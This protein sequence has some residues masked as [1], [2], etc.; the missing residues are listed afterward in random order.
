M[1]EILLEN[2][3]KFYGKKQDVIAVKN[4]NLRI[5]DEE[6]LVL[7]GPSGCG[8]TSTLRMIAGLED[9]SKGTICFDNKPINDF[10]PGQ[11]DIAMAFETYALYP[12]LNVWENIAFPMRTVKMNIK[13]IQDK[14]QW[15][16]QTLHISDVL[17]KRPNELSGGQQQRVS[18]ARAIVRKPNVFLL[19]EPLSHL[20]MKQKQH[21]RVEIKRLN[22]DLKITMVYVTHDQK[23]AMALADRIVVMNDGEL[24]QN[25]SPVDI[26]RDPANEF[27]AGFVGEPPMNF[28][29]CHIENENGEYSLQTDKNLCITKILNSNLKN[30]NKDYVRI[31][32]RPLKIQMSYSQES[33]ESLKASV[34]VYESIGEKGI[35]SIKIGEQIL[36]IVTKPEQKLYKNNNVWISFPYKYLYFFEPGTGKRLRDLEYHES[37]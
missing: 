33:S 37:V 25:G 31:G 17:Q 35:L 27:V 8:K 32:I 14:V 29:D 1:A 21:M 23:E 15:A 12:T 24:Q 36:S 28:I 5:H 11:R 19:D 13:E 18:L 9:I 16:A 22:T 6:F 30:Y 7:L 3:F 10:S 34:R 26:Y 2:I 20:D 4:L